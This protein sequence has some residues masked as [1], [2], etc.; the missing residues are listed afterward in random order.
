MDLR[1]DAKTAIVTGGAGGIGFAIASEF[2]ESGATVALFDAS[3]EGVR[4]AAERLTDAGGQALS[5]AVDVTDLNAVT[6]AVLE[7]VAAT[8]GLDIV[9]NCAGRG[10]PYRLLHEEEPEAWR[11]LI[12]VNLMGTVHVCYAAIPHLIERGGGSVVNIASDA[13][14]VGSAGE[15]VYSAAKGGVVSLT[16]SLAREL[17]RHRVTVNCV[18]PG[19]TDTPMLR[20][21]SEQAGDVVEKL[22]KATPLRRLAQPDDIAAA[23]VFLASHR[24]VHITGQVLSVSGGI[25][26]V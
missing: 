25:T 12:D 15:A 3:A 14:R 22:V 5:Y 11:W 26:M 20:A 21:F 23:V 2:A 4:E 17:A 13:A 24:A 10:T 6:G 1:V 9:V 18:A 16:K 19:P 8:G 7:T